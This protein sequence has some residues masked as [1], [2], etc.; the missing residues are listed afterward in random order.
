MW[1]VILEVAVANPLELAIIRDDAVL[2]YD[3]SLH[4]DS[5]SLLNGN[6]LCLNGSLLLLL[7]LLLWQLII[8]VMAA[9]CYCDRNFTIYYLQVKE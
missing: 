3:A 7:L 8:I 4:L 9:Y 2:I 1:L 6:L 5:S